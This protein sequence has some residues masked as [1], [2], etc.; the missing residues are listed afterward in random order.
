MKHT[1]DP[2]KEV[3][4]DS[5][6]QT[7]DAANKQS[8]STMYLVL[9]KLFNAG[10]IKRV[11]LPYTIPLVYI[12]NIS[13]GIKHS[14]DTNTYICT[15][16]HPY[17][18]MHG[19]PIHMSTSKRMDRLDFEIYKIGQN[20]ILLSMKTSLITE[21]ISHKYTTHMSN[22]RFKPVWVDSTVSNITI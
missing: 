15:S 14:I 20:N 8:N 5:T 2:H 13:G 7:C 19:H 18:Y 21:K 16:T 11:P 22:M 1:S 6:R 12:V 17:K 3:K 4:N 9:S 10:F